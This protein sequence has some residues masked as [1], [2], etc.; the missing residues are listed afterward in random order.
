MAMTSLFK[1][2]SRVVTVA[3]GSG[4]SALEQMSQER[5]HRLMSKT[6]TV[7]VCS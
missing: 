4:Q 6:A 1:P 3:S 2:G 5:R 7:E